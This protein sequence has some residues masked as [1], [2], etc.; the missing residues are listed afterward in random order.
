MRRHERTSTRSLYVHGP[1]SV[2]EVDAVSNRWPSGLKTRAFG[3]DL[4]R[5]GYFGDRHH[6][7][8]V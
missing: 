3:P 1:A 4:L 7:T 8:I 6:D 5:N 2:L